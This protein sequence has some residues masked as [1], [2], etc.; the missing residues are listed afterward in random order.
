MKQSSDILNKS[1]FAYIIDGVECTLL[2]AE[3]NRG[4]SNLHQQLNTQIRA[5]L[6]SYSHWDFHWGHDSACAPKRSG[7]HSFVFPSWTFLLTAIGEHDQPEVVWRSEVTTV[8]AW[9]PRRSHLLKNDTLFI[10]GERPRNR[11]FSF[12]LFLEVNEA[13]KLLAML[14]RNTKPNVSKT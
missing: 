2:N 10:I 8:T 3:V 1:R 9:T 7:A 6:Q 4:I 13:K 5:R 12:F 11:L 14:P